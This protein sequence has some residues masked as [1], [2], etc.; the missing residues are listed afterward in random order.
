VI[1]YIPIFIHRNPNKQVLKRLQNTSIRSSSFNNKGFCISLLVNQ[2]SIMTKLLP[3]FCLIFSI[4][5]CQSRTA[6]NNFDNNSGASTAVAAPREKTPEELRE[7]LAQKE[8]ESPA[9]YLKFTNKEAREN[10]IGETVMEGR[11][12]NTAT[13]AV[14]KDIVF[15]ANFLAPSGT[16]LGKEKFTRY[17]LVGPGYGVTYKFKTFAPK[18][19]KTVDMRVVSAVPTK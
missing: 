15:E 17:E 12:Q 10:M 19:T 8:S 3:L 1:Y 6:N 11:I 14:F 16:S 7:E 13:I 5:A 4:C 2:Y 18:E 9:E